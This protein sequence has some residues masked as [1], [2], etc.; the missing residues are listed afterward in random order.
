MDL[1]ARVAS[2][3]VVVSATLLGALSH[4][5]SSGRLIL[6]PYQDVA[7]V[8]TVCDG[9][10]NRALPG[11]VVPGRRYTEKEC[12]DAKAKALEV[13]AVEVSAC[14]P[15]VKQGQW[16]AL[17]DFGWNLGATNLC[18]SSL[19]RKLKTGDCRGAAEEFK[20]WVHAGGAKQPGL[21]IRRAW[22]YHEFIQEC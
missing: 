14:T 5:E 17:M 7:K 19:M 2:G 15:A 22:E 1:K 6:V 8:W 11:F 18:G 20:R 16:D 12:V 9:I 3:I 10:T 4:F 13:L 21:V